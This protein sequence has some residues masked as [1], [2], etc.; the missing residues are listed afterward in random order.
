MEV[1]HA[2]GPLV[3]EGGLIFRYVDSD[4]FYVFSVSSDGYFVVKKLEED[5]WTS[6]VEWTE[7]DLIETGEES[8]NLLAVLAEGPQLSFFI[9]EE[10]AA[11]VE[12][13][14][15]TEG[16]IALAAGSLDDAGV[17]IAF[18]EFVFWPVSA[19]NGPQPTLGIPGRRVPS[20]PT[21]Q[22]Q[23]EPLSIEERVAALHSQTP[24]FSDD[25]S[26]GS[27]EWDSESSDD[28]IFD[29]VDGVFYLNVL[30]IDW[31]TYSQTE[32]VYTD[33]LAEVDTTHSFGPTAVEYGLYFRNADGSNY[34]YYAISAGG[35]F[36]FWKRIDG[37]W[38][39]I[40]PWTE[41]D[42]LEAGEGAYNRLG[43][44]AEGHSIALLAN[45]VV[46]AEVEDDSM[47]AGA[48]GVFVRT[49]DEEDVEIAFDNVDV[50]SLAPSA[51][52]EPTP[53]ADEDTIIVDAAAVE[54][55][56]GDI[57]AGEPA[58]SETFRADTGAWDLTS[59]DEARLAIE[60]RRLHISV[61][62]PNWITWSLYTTPLSDFLLEVDAEVI[63]SLLDGSYG[64]VFRALDADNFYLFRI[65]PRGTFSFAKKAGG[66]WTTVIDWT[67]SDA[68]DTAEGTANRLSVLAE[69]DELAFL[70]NDVV[71]AQAVDA[72]LSEGQAGLAAGV[73]DESGLEIAFDNVDIW[74]LAQ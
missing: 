1:S 45:D 4:N 72:D 59:S 31:V 32:Y 29:F 55:R 22:P 68:I 36:N 37:E 41:S 20:T 65:S 64:V 69:G 44:L 43:V 14:S 71:V 39:E 28:S 8:A 10:L 35:H 66:E 67:A 63:T 17:D 48:L 54:A 38:Q 3:N 11:E 42:A 13:D 47:A 53:P 21:P 15:F 56:I 57:H 24:A 18:D 49:Y 62:S 19:A 50:W 61:D 16:G 9:N 7:S 70:V 73:Y 34:Y 5:V 30:P 26:A 27:G 12:D 60:R 74:D 2:A 23:D 58:V 46:L 51:Q 6:L 33:F 52:N 40:L 25:F